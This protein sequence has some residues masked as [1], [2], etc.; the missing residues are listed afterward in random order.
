MFICNRRKLESNPPFL[1]QVLTTYTLLLLLFSQSHKKKKKKSFLHE[2]STPLNLISRAQEM[3][4]L[5]IDN[6]FRNFELGN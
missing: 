4:F 3:A 5:T 6:E 1:S 2:D